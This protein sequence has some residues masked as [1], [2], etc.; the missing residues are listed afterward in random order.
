MS[1]GGPVLGVARVVLR[2]PEQPV[3]ED[4]LGPLHVVLE[5]D[6]RL[7]EV[8]GKNLLPLPVDARV[9]LPFHREQHD[10]E[11]DTQLMPDV[12]T[13]LEALRGTL[14]V[15][16]RPGQ[17]RKRASQDGVQRR[18]SS[19]ER[20][21]HDVLLDGSEIAGRDTSVGRPRR[22]RGSIH[23]PAS[24]GPVFRTIKLCG[25]ALGVALAIGHAA[26]A[27]EPVADKLVVLTFDDSKAS[28]YTVVRPLLKQYGFGAM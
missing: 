26:A 18:D 5:I 28:H 17:Q 10:V 4:D 7:N 27:L 23:W 24:R 9:E 11:A 21:G 2:L 16:E 22:H 19:A 8:L 15:L 6:E 14:D 25:L 20:P 13:R 1:V 3:L 12:A